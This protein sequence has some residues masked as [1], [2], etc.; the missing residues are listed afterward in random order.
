MQIKKNTASSILAFAANMIIAYLAYF[1][2]RVAYVAENWAEL[3]QGFGA[4]DMWEVVKGSLLFDTSALLYTNSLYAL[5]MLIPLHFKEKD[6]WQ[7]MAKWTFVVVNGICLA[8]NLCDAAYFRYTGRRTT[9]TVFNEFGA[10][11]NLGGIIGVEL[12]NHWYLVV[13]F[14]AMIAAIWWL[15]VKPHGSSHLRWR[16]DFIR[17]YVVQTLAFV[18]FVPLCIGGMRGGFTKAVRPVTISNANQY[19]NR[20]SEAAIVLNTPFSL[21]RTIGKATFADPGFFTEAQLNE[22]YSPVVVPADSLVMRKK[23]VV[24]LILESFSREFFG[25]LN[26]GMTTTYTPFLDSLIAKSLTF[27]YSYAN[28]RKSI[29]GMPSILS[30]IP[31]FGE[32]FFLTP[33]SLNEVSGIAG[34][35]AK[36]GYNTAFFHGAEN[37]SMGFEAF[38]KTTGYKQYYGRTEYDADKRFDGEDDFDGM[39]AIWDEEFLQFFAL[40]M[41]EIKE[42]FATAVFTA[43]SHHPYK[44][45]KK[46]ADRFVDQ[47]GDDNVLHKC[48]LYSDY[49]VQRFFETASKQ[50]WFQN[51]L[52]VITAD[53]TNISSRQEYQTDLGLFGVPI[54]FYDPSGEIAPERRHCI[55]Q[56]IDIMPT[57][58]GYLGYGN[59][60]VAFGQ[61]LLATADT[62]TWAV[63][64]NSGIYQ[65][66][67]GDYLLQMTDA[68]EV[69]AVY[70]YRKDVMLQN[71]LKDKIGDE[72]QQMHKQLKAIVQSYMQRMV[73]DQ[74][75]VR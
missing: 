44:V 39:W 45:P 26:E 49:A 23:N 61:N 53:H 28:G 69:K 35:L 21:M 67:K 14:V 56:Q 19:V 6:W 71:N 41:S 73:G 8:A 63:N 72:Q 52:F 29:D 70:N 32:P 74:L 2:S 46:Y 13:L 66:V 9:A 11:G 4:L 47:P 33:A 48:V 60:Y 50:P 1:V 34:E 22:I 18:A 38:A 20:P 16:E 54:I 43:S 51:T 55:A 57:V 12:L 40:K 27:D 62:D 31:R 68:G 24:V 36:T 15:Y 64:H 65:Y 37:G 58:L 3:G 10:E 30:S 17:Y 59:P 25:S 42:P 75:V 7:T 5:M